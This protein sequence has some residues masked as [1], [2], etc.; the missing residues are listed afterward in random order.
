LDNEAREWLVSGLQL[1]LIVIRGIHFAA[2]ALVTGTLVFRAAVAEPALNSTKATAS[3]VRSQILRTAWIGL[4][5]ALVSGVIWLQLEAESMSGLPFGEATTWKV[6]SIVLSET[7]FG[8][9][10]EIRITLAI[11]LFACLAYDRIAPLRWSALG[12]AL[13]LMA[14]IAWT[15]HGGA[16]LGEIG[17]L[18]LTADVL[19]LIAAAVWIGGIVPFAFLLASARHH[20]TIEWASLALGSVLRFSTLG[21]IAVGTLLVTGIVNAWILVGS[22]RALFFTEYGQLLALKLVVFG[23]MLTF[24]ALNRFCLTPQL[25]PPTDD[26]ARRDALRQLTR[27]STAE[28]ALGLAIFAIVGLLGTL[29]PA[30][31]MIHSM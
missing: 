1:S 4:A 19:H 18:H 16:T 7:Q 25:T 14:T 28:F 6:L 3:I 8:L 5:I 29:R 2:T 24:A 12:M 30:A 9:V 31:H 17:N 20:H 21:I 13:G 26:K 10:S 23:L 11:I 15:G 22:V 27:N